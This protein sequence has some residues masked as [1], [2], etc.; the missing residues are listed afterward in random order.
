MNVVVE[1]P[2]RLLLIEDNPGDARLIRQYSATRQQGPTTSL[3]RTALPADWRSCAAVPWTS[4]SR[5][6][7]SPT[8]GAIFMSGSTA[9]AVAGHDAFGA[10]GDAPFLPKPF[11]PVALGNKVREVLDRE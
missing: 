4:S 7:P 1:R 8:A 3:R 5:T 10:I 9:G 11:G 6:S 2:A